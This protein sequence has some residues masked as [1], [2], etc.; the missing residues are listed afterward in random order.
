MHAVVRRYTGAS[1]LIDQM[2]DRQGEIEEL[3]SDI[4]GFDAYYA[5]RDGDA[6]TTVTVCADRAG[7]E[8]STGVAADWVRKNL[9]DLSASPPAVSEGDV[10]LTFTRH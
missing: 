8:K 4:P 2:V 7:T 3:I 6:L 9:P 10:F 5:V 1:R